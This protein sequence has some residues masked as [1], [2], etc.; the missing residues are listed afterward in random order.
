M[1]SSRWKKKYIVYRAN[2]TEYVD[3]LAR[4]AGGTY[5]EDDNY[6]EPAKYVKHEFE[7]NIQPDKPSEY[8]ARE[9]NRRE[10][11]FNQNG[12]IKCFGNDELFIAETSPA[13]TPD[14]IIYQNK[15]YEVDQ[16]AYWDS[17]TIGHYRS[18]AMLT[19]E[20]VSDYEAYN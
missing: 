19:N 11:G 7:M 20:K 14:K 4:V 6:I 15:V 5:D 9:T 12:L 8:E 17:E 16:C 10:K 2:A 13:T 1:I 18:R 3:G